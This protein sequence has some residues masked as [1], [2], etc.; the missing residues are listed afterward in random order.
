[1]KRHA[2]MLL[3]ACIGLCS[4]VA[5]LA[6]PEASRAKHRRPAAFGAT[7]IQAAA[8][9]EQPGQSPGWIFGRVLGVPGSERPM[10]SALRPAGAGDPAPVNGAGPP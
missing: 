1:M 9:P 7:R 10:M 5:F 4:A 8:P 2:S 6:K 3:L